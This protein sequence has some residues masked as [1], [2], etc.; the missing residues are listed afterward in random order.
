MIFIGEII[1]ESLIDPSVLEEFKEYLVKTRTATVEN[2]VPRC[3]ISGATGFR[4]SKG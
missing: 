2:F 1:R 3:G 4:L